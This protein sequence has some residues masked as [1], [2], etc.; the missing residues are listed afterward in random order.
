MVV[1]AWA[2]PGSILRSGQEL[3]GSFEKADLCA[4]TFFV[5]MEVAIFLFKFFKT[6]IILNYNNLIY[7]RVL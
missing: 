2:I 1:V 6:G 7:F 5:V 4:K 3:L